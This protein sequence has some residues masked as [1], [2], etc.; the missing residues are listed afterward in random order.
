MKPPAGPAPQPE[1][2]KRLVLNKTQTPPSTPSGRTRA[3]PFCGEDILTVAIKCKHCGSDLSGK[4][5]ETV[6]RSETI[7]T[8]ALL[9]PM[10]AAFLAWFW[11]GNMPLLYDPA[12]K[13]YGIMAGTVLL[14]AFLMAA[15]ANSVGA[16]TDTD[17]TPSGRKREGP[18]EWFFLGI[19][20]W[21]VAFPMW[22]HRRSKYGLKNLCG[23]AILIALVSVA[24][25]GLMSAA[26]ENQKAEIRRDIKNSQRQIEKAQRE[27]ERAEEEA[28]RQLRN[29]GY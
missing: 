15:E 26:F 11:L 12:S 23:K 8:I 14:T 25:L 7:G 13:L 3:C 2:Q 17:K 28:Q 16:G 20:L 1:Q 5:E 9:I 24:V 19:V 21:I 29:L 27:F 18:I 22:M 4:K 10:C 6:K